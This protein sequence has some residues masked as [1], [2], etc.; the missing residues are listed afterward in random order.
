[1]HE[2][3][4]TMKSTNAKKEQEN[5]IDHPDILENILILNVVYMLI[6]IFNH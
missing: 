4:Y 6:L 2:I 3:N 5:F 1:M